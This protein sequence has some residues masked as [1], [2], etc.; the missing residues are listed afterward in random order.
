MYSFKPMSKAEREEQ[1]EAKKAAEEE[2]KSGKKPAKSS[3]PSAIKNESSMPSMS[4]NDPT[5]ARMRAGAVP[6]P[7]RTSEEGKT[8]IEARSLGKA[9]KG[10][11]GKEKKPRAKKIP[12]IFMDEVSFV[13][14]IFSEQS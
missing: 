5:E 6:K 11:E 1:K 14:L 12:V 7:Q 8:L 4:S 2:E 3:K 10:E 9:Q 13:Y